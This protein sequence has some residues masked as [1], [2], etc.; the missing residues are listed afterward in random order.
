M[1]RN[2]HDEKSGR[3]RNAG[4]DLGKHHINGGV[5]R[6][7]PENPAVQFGRKLIVGKNISGKEGCKKEPFFDKS[8]KCNEL[9]RYISDYRFHKQVLSNE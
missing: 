4:H 7:T 2:I 9:L 8:S 1:P 3:V 6:G 5:Q